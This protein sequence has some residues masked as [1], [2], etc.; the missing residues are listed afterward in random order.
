MGYIEKKY[1]TVLYIRLYRIYNIDMGLSENAIKKNKFNGF[2]SN[3]T[4]IKMAYLITST[5]FSE[6]NHGSVLRDSGFCK[7]QIAILGIIWNNSN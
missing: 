1:C 5:K 4:N 3:V 6:P 7:G 2:Y